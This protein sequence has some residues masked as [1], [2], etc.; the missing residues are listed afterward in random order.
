M[1]R[2]RRPPE[3]PAGPGSPALDGPRGD[4]EA[5]GLG[6]LARGLALTGGM[7]LVAVVGMTVASVLGRYLFGVPIPGDYELTELACGIAVF[8]FFPYCHMTQGNV[9]VDFFTSR[10]S[11]RYRTALDGLHSIAF[12]A[13]AGLIAWRLFV[14]AVRKLEDGETTLFLEIPIHVAYFAALVTAGL[15]TTVCVQVVHRHLQALRR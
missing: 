11:P 5:S 9:V 7:L 8:A 1:R 14:G 3:P 6:R 4:R 15:L 2:P 12:T 13:M 10:L